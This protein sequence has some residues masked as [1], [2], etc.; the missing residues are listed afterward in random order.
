MKMMDGDLVSTKGQIFLSTGQQRCLRTLHDR[1]I[2]GAYSL[3]AGVC[4]GARGM[5]DG[6]ADKG[7]ADQRAGDCD[8]RFRA[9]ARQDLVHE[10][11]RNYFRALFASPKCGV[12]REGRDG[13]WEEEIGSLNVALQIGAG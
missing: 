4:P 9:V 1:I 12:A 7:N 13:A 5:L 2:F 8:R 11:P 6:R 10:Y 3:V